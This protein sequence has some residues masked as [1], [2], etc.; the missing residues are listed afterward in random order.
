[1]RHPPR[2]A[3]EEQLK[4]TLLLCLVT[5]IRPHTVLCVVEESCYAGPVA[6]CTGSEW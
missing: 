2:Q 3:A 4:R 1:M 5:S 6:I